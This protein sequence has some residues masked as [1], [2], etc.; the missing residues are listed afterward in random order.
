MADPRT[1]RELQN[2]IT[3]AQNAVNTEIAEQEYA[4]TIAN[5]EAAQASAVAGF[6]NQIKALETQ[7]E[8]WDGQLT[9]YEELVE[10]ATDNVCVTLERVSEALNNFRNSIS[11]TSSSYSGSG[12]SNI[13]DD[14]VK[15][16]MKQNSDAWHTSSPQDRKILERNNIA[17]AEGRGWKFDPITGKWFD[18]YGIPIYHTGTFGVGGKTVTGG[19]D[20][21]LALLKKGEA[22]IPTNLMPNLM[23]MLS[24]GAIAGSIVN[25]NQKTSNVNNSSNF[26]IGNVITNN[27][28]SFVSEL[29]RIYE[30]NQ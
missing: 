19:Q 29:K 4:K 5:L 1:I 2:A 16:L 22:V 30:V 10:N 17:L 8:Y 9:H 12:S 25:N 20:Q 21:L 3:D 7:I 11:S 26:N 15:S 13:S 14:T 18:E 28:T 23:K 24:L 27:P 6:E